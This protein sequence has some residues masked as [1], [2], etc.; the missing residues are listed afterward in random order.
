MTLKIAHRA[1]EDDAGG[2][3]HVYSVR[4]TASS[5]KG[6]CG[7]YVFPLSM[8]RPLLFRKPGIFTLSFSLVTAIKDQLS[9][10]IAK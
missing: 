4:L 5:H 8:E 10:S 6:V 7:L 2:H 1:S 9:Q 3:D